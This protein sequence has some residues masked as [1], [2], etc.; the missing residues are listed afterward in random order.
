MARTVYVVE[1]TVYDPAASGGAG[2]EVTKYYAT[3]GFA[4]IGTD[5]PADTHVD[6]RVKQPLQINRTMF[7]PNT[8]RGR[9]L[10]G[11]GDIVLVNGDGEL[12]DF[13]T[14]GV[15]GRTITVRKGTEGA[16]YPSGFPVYWSGT[17]QGVEVTQEFVFLKIRDR[18]AELN[19]PLQTTKY[20][21][22]GL[23]TLEGTEDTLKGKPKPICYGVVKNIAP[24]CVETAKLIYQV[25][26]ATVS[27]VDAVYDRGVALKASYADMY[28]AVGGNALASPVDAIQTSPDG[29][30]WTS[31]TSPGGNPWVAVAYGVGLWVA[32]G[33]GGELA[34]SED[35]V[36]W[37]S[38]TSG[39]DSSS[40]QSVAFGYANGVARFV[41]AGADGKMAYA[42]ASNIATWTRLTVLPFGTTTIR[43]MTY[44]ADGAGVWIG[45]AGAIIAYSPDGINWQ[46]QTIAG[47][48]FYGITF[49]DTVYC[50]VGDTGSPTTPVIYTTQDPVG[51]WTSRT[52]P[53]SHNTAANES[54]RGVATD[55]N[56]TFVVV[57]VE[58]SASPNLGAL[59][60]TSSD[61]GA[62]WTARTS[63]VTEQQNGV[64][65]GDG[66]YVAVGGISTADATIQTSPDGITWT[67]RTVAD[68]Q[69]INRVAFGEGGASVATYA[70]SADLLDNTLAP[71]AGKFKA[72]YAA[73]GS[74]FRLGAAPDGLV[75]ADVTQGAAASDRT[76]AQIWEAIL[77]ERG[78]MAAGD[79]NATDVS[80]LD[81]ANNDVIGY[82]TD[83][84]AR[85][86]DVID[87]VK[88]SA[89]AASY[90]DIS[91]DFRI[92]QF[93][94]PSGAA[95][96]SITANDLIRPLRRILPTEQGQGIPQY[97]TIL[98]YQKNYTP[99]V[100]DVAASVTDARKAFLAKEW[101]EIADT[102]AT[103]QTKHLLAIESVEDTLL[104]VAAD[105]TTEADRRQ[106]LRGADRQMF[107]LAL[108]LNDDTDTLELNDVIEL[109]HSRYGLSGGESFRIIGLNINAEKS[110]LLAVV[111]G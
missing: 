85:V 67:S 73:G 13:T 26:D 33:D 14:Y 81:T 8:T 84:E 39:F 12:D 29:T 52:V 4:T 32:G 71:A 7:A 37:T 9:S 80:T 35:G 23:G 41:I 94:A 20:T 45:A 43:A 17:M 91:G 22:G 50:A 40:I 95:V 69:A 110:E 104:D 11:V 90:V 105:A 75:T 101:R 78:G 106:T 1:V 56:S 99:Q 19:V 87:L 46:S 83:Q 72:Y 70:S 30:T 74:Y 76:T 18:L 16:A 5:T 15:D 111:W 58:D 103:V 47:V 2:A 96:L 27:A 60:A 53:A 28:V 86:A 89:G 64:V 21:G 34:T 59:I 93:L 6:E 66:L 57:G 109:T 36:N 42:D 31:R 100:T 24:P 48:T 44:A 68:A 55:G 61:D 82:W 25:A 10:V 38:R 62:N 51:T 54:Y 98:R 97:R 77:D 102:D 88:D 65:Y 92:K 107:E 79:W 108:P 49:G 3:K 63:A